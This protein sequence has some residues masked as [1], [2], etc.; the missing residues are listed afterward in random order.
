M[1]RKV[2]TK[3]RDIELHFEDTATSP[4]DQ[5]YRNKTLSNSIFRIFK[6]LSG[7]EPTYEEITGQADIQLDK[8]I[9]KRTR[10]Q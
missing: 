10:T 1:G 7:R 3:N 2:K 4:E 6:D 5:K 8:R 9:L